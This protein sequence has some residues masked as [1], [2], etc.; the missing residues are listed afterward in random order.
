S[1]LPTKHA[2]QQ[3]GL[4]VAAAEQLSIACENLKSF[5]GVQAALVELK[6]VEDE[7][8]RVRAHALAPLLR[9]PGPRGA[10]V[11]P[12]PRDGDAPGVRSGGKVRRPRAGAG[13]R[14][15]RAPGER[16]REH[17]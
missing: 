10:G 17:R 12:L 5:T 13:P 3:T 9:G 1:E 16:D 14:Q 6:R 8:D 11:A 7:G 4:F 2:V 15:R